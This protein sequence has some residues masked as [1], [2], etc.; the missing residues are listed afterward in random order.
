MCLQDKD[1]DK[2]G[3]TWEDE[4]KDSGDDI[5]KIKAKQKDI[6]IQEVF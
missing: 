6:N 4:Y 1:K 3:E 5:V 2:F